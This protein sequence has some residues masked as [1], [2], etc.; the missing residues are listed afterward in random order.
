MK[1]QQKKEKNRTHKSKVKSEHLISPNFLDAM[2]YPEMP[3]FFTS[4]TQEFGKK[5]D[6]SRK[7]D[8]MTEL[9]EMTEAESKERQRLNQIYGDLASS[10]HRYFYGNVYLQ[11][12][13]FEAPSTWAAR[14]FNIRHAKE[15][16][17]TWCTVGLFFPDKVA[18]VCVFN[19]SFVLI[20]TKYH[21]RLQK[22]IC[23]QQEKIWTVVSGYDSNLFH[24]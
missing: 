2:R 5:K 14:D 20:K 9:D 23:E 12:H 22:N 24:F 21:I 8:E 11:T 1:L 18:V 15:L 6:K 13:L 16:M 17:R 19:V 10:A 4:L 3:E 7:S